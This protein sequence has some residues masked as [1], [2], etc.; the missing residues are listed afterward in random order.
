MQF[1]ELQRLLQDTEADHVIEVGRLATLVRDMS[2]VLVDLG[3]PPTP[4]ISR[5][6]RTAGNVLEAVDLILERLQ[7]AYTSDHDP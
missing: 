2:T 5:H 3:M 1:V 4:E 6:P 7:E